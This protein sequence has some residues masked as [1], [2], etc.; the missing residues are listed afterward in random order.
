MA[1][2]KYNVDSNKNKRT[3]NDIVFASEYFLKKRGKK[4]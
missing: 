1:R 2:S 4:L 3:Y